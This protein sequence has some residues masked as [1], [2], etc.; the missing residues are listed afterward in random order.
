MGCTGSSEAGGSS[1][2]GGDSYKVV[3]IGEGGV[4]KSAVTI[5]FIQGRFVEEYDPTIGMKH[6]A[7]PRTVVPDPN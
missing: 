6:L 2:G 7:P 3:V 1:S 4:G 5:Q